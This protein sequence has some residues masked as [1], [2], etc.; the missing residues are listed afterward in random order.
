MHNKQSA[1]KPCLHEACKQ[2]IEHMIYLNLAAFEFAQRVFLFLT[3]RS[4]CNEIV[5]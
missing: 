3:T 5:E 1:E 4:F 2:R